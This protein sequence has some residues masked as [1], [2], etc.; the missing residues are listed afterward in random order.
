MDDGLSACLS[1]YARPRSSDRP[2]RSEGAGRQTGSHSFIYLY[3]VP[4][5]PPGPL[6]QAV[7]GRTKGVVAQLVS[8][9]TATQTKDRSPKKRGA[10]LPPPPN[11]HPPK[12]KKISPRCTRF[13][14]L[15]EQGQKGRE[16]GRHVDGPSYHTGR[17]RR[18]R[19]YQ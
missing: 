17:E 3:E 9:S 14:R 19:R 15:G 5:F 7:I 13:G 10:C 1:V 6:Q 12:K 16:R 11:P 18:R 8:T 2:R 4:S